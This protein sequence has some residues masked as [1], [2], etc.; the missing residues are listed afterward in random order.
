MKGVLIGSDFLQQGSEVKVIEI[1][2]N[3]AVFNKGADFLNLAPLF[4]MLDSGSVTEFHFIYTENQAYEGSGD[5]VYRLEEMIQEKC[6]EYSMSYEAHVV[7]ENS[8]TVPAIEDADNK[9]ILRQSYDTSALIDSTYCADK[10]GFVELMS[11]SAN[12]IPSYF[13]SSAD[14]LYLDTLESV[15]YT[16]TKPNLIEKSRYAVYDHNNWPA[17][18]QVTGSDGLGARKIGLDSEDNFVQEFIYDSSNEKDDRYSTIRSFDIIYGSNLD[19]IHLGGY[20]HTCLV[21]MDWAEDEYFDGKLYDKGRI[22]YI[23]SALIGN[24]KDTYHSNGLDRILMGDGTTKTASELEINDTIKTAIFDYTFPTGSNYPVDNTL[25]QGANFPNHYISGSTLEDTLTWVD[26]ALISSGSQVKSGL[27]IEIEL[28]DGK[29]WYDTHNTSYVIE[30]S[31]SLLQ[32]FEH[33]NKM[34]PGDKLIT[35]NPD[36]SS[37]TKREISSLNVVWSDNQPLINFDFEPYDYYLVDFD[38]SGSDFLI[39][40][41]IC[42]YCYAINSWA[43][44]GHYFCDNSCTECSGGGGKSERHLKS[45]IEFI[46]E[47]KMGI[48]MYHFNYKDIADGIGRFVG[49]MVDDLQRLGFEDALIHTEDG[50]LVDYSKIDVPFGNISN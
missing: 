49:T 8:I 38:A 1:N 25:P 27:M 39:M 5:N 45:D 15:D 4:E 24:L 21:D 28:T 26:S 34:V 41:N 44:C 16:S 11:G 6:S 29:S 43:P 7:A 46:G 3:S 32:H 12:S 42:A 9:F 17:L 37:I 36:D 14:D 40:H 2:T 30:G 10:L 13:S 19:T 20:H 31:G 18:Y 33:V 22:K 50:I 47:S 48:P 35:V 23:N